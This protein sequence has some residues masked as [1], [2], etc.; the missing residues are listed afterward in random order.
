MASALYP[1]FKQA[2]LNKEHDLDTDV[3]RAMLISTS[4]EPSFTSSD[5]QLSDIVG[6]PYGSSTAEIIASPTITNGQF[7][8]GSNTTFTAVAADASKNVDVIIIYNDTTI[9]DDLIAWIDG[10]T[11]VLPNGGNLTINWDTTIFAL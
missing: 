1:S 10:F 11:P 6:G 7:V 2:L 3:I 8:A 5:T 4:D 9:N